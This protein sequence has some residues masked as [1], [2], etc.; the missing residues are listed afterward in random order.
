MLSVLKHLLVL[1]REINSLKQLVRCPIN[2]GNAQCQPGR[3]SVFH[4]VNVESR[5]SLVPVQWNVACPHPRLAYTITLEQRWAVLLLLP[6]VPKED[7]LGRS[8][9]D[10]MF[11]QH[12]EI[13]AERQIHRL[14]Q[15]WDLA[16]EAHMFLDRRCWVRQW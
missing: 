4:E 9:D 2:I 14:G 10:V 5:D 8:G 11:S 16:C 12:F 6:K 3:A 7:T 1:V 15:E 13:A